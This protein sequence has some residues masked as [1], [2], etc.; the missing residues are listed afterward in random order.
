MQQIEFISKDLLIMEE[1]LMSQ[2]AVR[3]LASKTFC[4]LISPLLYDKFGYDIYSI[5]IFYWNTPY[6]PYADCHAAFSKNFDSR[7][8][9]R[10]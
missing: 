4:A 6:S 8:N 2:Y 5:Y 3:K 7:K 1:E 10:R 9:D